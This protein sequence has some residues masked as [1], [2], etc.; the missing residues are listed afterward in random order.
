M[1]HY[2]PYFIAYAASL[3][4]RPEDMPKGTMANANYMRWIKARWQ[5]FRAV[6]PELY[7]DHGATPAAHEPFGI[8][9]AT[10]FPAVRAA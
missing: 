2:Q 10:R 6:R 7:D 5:E 8:W 9:L 1:T 3:G 4:S